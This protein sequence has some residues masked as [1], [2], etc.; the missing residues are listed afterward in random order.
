[1]ARI[2]VTGGAGYVGSHT[3]KLASQAGH[4]C[5]VYD[6]LSNGHRDFV[7]WGPLIEADIRDAERLTAAL[8]Q[9]RI[10]AVLHLAALAYVGQS[11]GEPEI[12]RAHV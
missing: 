12:G 7:R 2:L 11:V 10:D 6:N 5:I 3:V 4:D 1:M 8:H 9:E